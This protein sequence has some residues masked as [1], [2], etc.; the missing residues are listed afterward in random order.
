MVGGNQTLDL[1]LA[2]SFFTTPPIIRLYIDC[3][4]VTYIL[5]QTKCKL[6]I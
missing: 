3:S 6:I 4:F 2:S 5:E 1:T